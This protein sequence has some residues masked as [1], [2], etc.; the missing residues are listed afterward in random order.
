MEFNKD[1][2]KLLIHQFLAES[3]G[4]QY[5]EALQIIFFE[6]RRQNYYEA[7]DKQKLLMLNILKRDLEMF[8]LSQADIYR[9][10][11][12]LFQLNNFRKQEKLSDH[13][14]E[15][16]A[17]ILLMAKLKQLIEAN[18]LIG[19]KLQFPTLQKPR[20]E[21]LRKQSWQIQQYDNKGSNHKLSKSIFYMRTITVIKQLTPSPVAHG[22]GEGIKAF[23]DIKYFEECVTNGDGEEVEKYLSRFTNAEDNPESFSI[24]FEIRRQNYYEAHDKSDR[25]MMLDIL[26]RDLKVLTL[27]QADLYR[28]LVRLFQLNNFRCI[29]Q[30]KLSDHGDEKSVRILLMAKLKQLIEANPLIGYKLQLPSLQKSRLETLVKLSLRWQ[31]QQ[32][33][34]KGSNHK[35][36]KNLLYEDP[37]CEQ[38]TDTIPCSS[39]KCVSN[40]DWEEVE[41]YLSRFT[42]AE[43][44]PEP[45]SIFFEIR[46]QNYYEPHDKDDRKM[47]L[48]ILKR[49]LEVFTLSQVDLYRGLK[50]R[51]GIW[52]MTYFYKNQEKL[53]DHGD[54][55]STR[56]LL[57]AKLKRLI[58]ANPL[59]GD[60]LQFPSLHMSRLETLVKQ[61]Y[62]KD[63]LSSSF[64]S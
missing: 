20:I 58:E 43:D 9:G 63:F 44:N 25:K 42:N 26:K 36:P 21:T 7:H 59:I 60:K 55:N 14:D 56:I 62:T 6:I 39:W 8:T 54:E 1:E 49:D 13:G 33:D 38:A 31:I 5:R 48:D 17:R 45:F 24:F 16:S 4:E 23:Y 22:V 35:L 28:G 53:S 2:L 30:Q 46:R 18:Q 57:M 61:R 10:L 3:D 34:T 37:Y 51:I 40:G 12:P 19:D 11:V 41:K 32:C 27:S 15:K 64:A 47:M 52:Y 50:Y 29:L